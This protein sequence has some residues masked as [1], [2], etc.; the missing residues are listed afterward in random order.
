MKNFFILFVA[1]ILAV[2]NA[3]AQNNKGGKGTVKVYM[4]YGLTYYNVKKISGMPGGDEWLKKNGFMTWKEIV[5]YEADV[6]LE[7]KMNFLKFRHKK[8]WEIQE[9]SDSIKQR[10]DWFGWLPGESDVEKKNKATRERI[11][12][13]QKDVQEK[14]KWVD[15]DNSFADDG[16]A[17][18]DSGIFD[19]VCTVLDYTVDKDPIG[20]RTNC[21]IEKRLS[22]GGVETNDVSVWYLNFDGLE[23]RDS[24]NIST[25][26]EKN[27]AVFEFSV[28]STRPPQY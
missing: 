28:Q 19:K 24:D 13:I 17:C 23:V 21:K 25:K 5:K 22:F 4:M 15:S 7:E 14:Q 20:L 1:V 18:V 8:E 3:A 27:G 6:R 16:S 11:K 9:A 26:I 10:V 12:A 2:S